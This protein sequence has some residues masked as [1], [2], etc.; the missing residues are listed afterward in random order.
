MLLKLYFSFFK[1][2]ILGFGGGYAMLALIQNEMVNKHGW[3]TVE[4]FAD[5]VAIS[6]ITPGPIS[7]NCATYVGYNVYGGTLGAIVATLGTV[8]PSLVLM[9][10]A[11]VFYIKL[12]NN[13]HLRIIIRTLR[14]ITISLILSAAMLLMNKETFIDWFSVALCLGALY[15]T[16]KNVNPVYVIIT[17]A[18]LGFIVYY[19]CPQLL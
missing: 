17:S 2:G 3:L 16:Y 9:T 11:S 1:I 19:C 12:Q 5:I 4:Q 15:V 13:R 10:L 14:P 8:T 7:I 18:A 6:Q